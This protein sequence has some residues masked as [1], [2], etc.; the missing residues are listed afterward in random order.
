MAIA[1]LT[2][3]QLKKRQIAL[4]LPRNCRLCPRSLRRRFVRALPPN[5]PRGI[6][7]STD[8]EIQRILIAILVDFYLLKTRL[9]LHYLKQ[10]GNNVNY[11]WKKKLNF[12][13]SVMK[14]VCEYQWRFS[15]FFKRI[16]LFNKGR[17]FISVRKRFSS[18]Y[19]RSPHWKRIT[20]TC[21]DSRS[22]RRSDRDLEMSNES[23]D[24]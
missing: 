13:Y 17:C 16:S 19:V 15:V 8:D 9:N 20:I 18:F 24:T 4:T 1:V 2:D 21:S 7:L 6:R 12:W 3:Q 10:N 23:N 11:L 22:L 5:L 14:C